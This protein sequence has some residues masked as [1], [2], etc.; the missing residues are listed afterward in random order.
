M[1]SRLRL[2]VLSLAA[3]PACSQDL[4]PDP[5]DPGQ[6]V[7][8]SSG[9]TFYVSSGGSDS[10]LGTSPSSAWQTI[11]KA[12]AIVQA[13]DT[14]VLSG[15]FSQQVIAPG[16]SGTAAAPITYLA[17]SAGA[18]LDQPGLVGTIPYIAYFGA[19]SFIVVRGIS[20]TN[21]NYVNAPVANKGVVL[22]SSNHITISNCSFTHVQMQII[23]SDDNVITGN[24]FKYFVASYVN[25]ATGKP[26]PNHPNT[27]GDM[28]NVVSGSDRNL[29]QYN[30]MSYAGHSLIEIGNGFGGTNANNEIADNILDNPWYKPLILSDD[31][32]G[33]IVER[34]HLLDANSQAV[35]YSTIPGQTGQ[36]DVSSAGVQ[37]SGNNYIFRHNLLVNNTATYGV[38]TIGARW[39]TDNTH[40]AGVLVES[41]NNQ[42]YNNTVYGNHAAAAV[43]FVE[44]LS[45]Q[46]IAAGRTTVPRLTGN[47]I[48]NN[49]FWGNG[50]TP[51]SWNKSTFYSTFIYHSATVAPPWPAGGRNGNKILGNDLDG[52]IDANLNDVTYN[53]SLTHVVQTLSQLQASAA[54]DVSGNLGVDPLFVNPS[55]GDFSLASNSPA[56]G[57]GM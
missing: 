55:A 34:N 26:D 19:R 24:T 38:I 44:F 48:Q 53:A 54:A 1:T 16:H 21:T 52:V 39:Y 51:Y 22:R 42:I 46:D 27:Q 4:P 50:G 13:G 12:N 49:I 33:T 5:D 14:V 36:L 45:S 32:A 2:V 9:R 3:L 10:H 7:H 31:G 25:P 23:G 17:G 40:P 11:A 47:V 29:I 30:D 20:F 57:K 18:V 15:S 35:L 56:A 41:M 43:S 28:L 8:P 6:D 37:F